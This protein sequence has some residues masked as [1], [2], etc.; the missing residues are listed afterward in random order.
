MSSRVLVMGNEPLLCDALH[1]ELVARGVEVVL[2]RELSDARRALSEG[3]VRAVVVELD[4][5]PRTS[6]LGVLSIA[7][8]VAPV[9]RRILV[10]P[11]GALLIECAVASGLVEQ[12]VLPPRVASRQNGWVDWLASVCHPARRPHAA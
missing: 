10:A 5:S 9:A 12:L 6:G 11:H 7:R 2:G 4:P 8:T 3:D 1:S